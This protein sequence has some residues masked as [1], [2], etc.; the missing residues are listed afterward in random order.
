VTIRAKAKLIPQSM[1][2]RF[3]CVSSSCPLIFFS[4]YVIQTDG[5][6]VLEALPSRMN[7]LSG[8][9]LHVDGE[10]NVKFPMAP[11]RAK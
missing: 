8:S 4:T 9:S 2:G 1:R 3:A 5:C 6:P 11:E 10:H 7:K